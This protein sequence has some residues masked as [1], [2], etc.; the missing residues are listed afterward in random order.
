MLT[1]ERLDEIAA[2][3]DAQEAAVARLGPPPETFVQVSVE[4]KSARDLLALAR[5][6]V[7][8]TEEVM[9]RVYSKAEAAFEEAFVDEGR[10][11]DEALRTAIRAAIAEIARG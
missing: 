11:N 9:R 7:A 6:V 4:V 8:S 5:R 1:K 3:V 10:T 2:R